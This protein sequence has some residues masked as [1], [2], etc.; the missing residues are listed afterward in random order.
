MKEIQEKKS[1]KDDAKAA[2]EEKKRLA[3]EFALKKKST[4]GKD[5]FRTMETEKYSKFDE[6]SGLPTHDAKGK[7]LSE[8]LVNKCKKAANTQ[9][10]KY[11]KWL[12]E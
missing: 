4:P 9:E 2:K 10:N 11:Q 3:D 5:W 7:A 8:A 6:E 12:K 1:G